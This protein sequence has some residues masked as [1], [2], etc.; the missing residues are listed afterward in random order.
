M[1]QS[2]FLTTLSVFFLSITVAI[3]VYKNIQTETIIDR[4]DKR[5]IQC[6]KEIQNK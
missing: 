6:E 1:K 3:L 2:I 4:I 5:L